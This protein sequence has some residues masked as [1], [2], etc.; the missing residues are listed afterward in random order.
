MQLQS[1]ISRLLILIRI[2]R[3][4]ILNKVFILLNVKVEDNVYTILILNTSKLKL[5]SFY[6]SHLP[7]S[8]F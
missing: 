1:L 3:L 8:F 4:N 6:T 2:E 5:E 7:R